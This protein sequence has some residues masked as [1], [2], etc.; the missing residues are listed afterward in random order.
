M[1]IHFGNYVYQQRRNRGWTRK[2]LAGKADV[3][4]KL[5][6]RV[7]QNPTSNGVQPASIGGIALAFGTTAEELEAAW[8]RTKVPIVVFRKT[9]IT[10]LYKLCKRWGVKKDEASDS[11]ATWILKQ[12]D[13]VQRKVLGLDKKRVPMA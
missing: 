7:E 11:V 6:T 13:D 4:E 2:E 10:P 9:R 12:P 3:S 5:I 8:R 1:H